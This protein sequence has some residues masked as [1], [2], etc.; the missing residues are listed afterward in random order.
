MVSIKLAELENKFNSTIYLM[1]ASNETVIRKKLCHT[2]RE[3]KTIK[4]NDEP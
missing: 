1:I 4:I 2:F 3:K